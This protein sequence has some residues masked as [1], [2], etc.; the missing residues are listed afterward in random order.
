MAKLE[1]TLYMLCSPQES[2]HCCTGGVVQGCGKGVKRAFG[3]LM[4]W[5][6]GKFSLE[7]CALL[8]LRCRHPC[9]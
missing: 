1:I 8:L 7:G 3:I 4:V 2:E 9:D 5:G 6:A